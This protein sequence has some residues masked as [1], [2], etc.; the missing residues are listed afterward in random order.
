MIIK[1]I[2]NKENER[3]FSCSSYSKRRS[4][5]GDYEGHCEAM[6]DDIDGADEIKKIIHQFVDLGSRDDVY[7]IDL[8][9]KS[10]TEPFVI[11]YFQKFSGRL[12]VMND[13]GKTIDSL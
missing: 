12:F 4:S 10:I 7:R 6:A 8:F 13:N 3:V 11:I 9:D 5:Q 1:I 2:D